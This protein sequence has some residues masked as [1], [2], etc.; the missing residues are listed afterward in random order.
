MSTIL[1]RL[2]AEHQRTP[3][4]SDMCALCRDA[5]ADV[6]DRD[7][8]LSIISSAYLIC[9]HHDAPAHILDVLSDPEA[10]TAAQIDAMLPYQP[11]ARG[12]LSNG[13]IRE[14][15]HK[16][17]RYMGQPDYYSDTEF[18][19]LQDVIGFARAIIAAAAG[20]A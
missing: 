4:H 18:A 16:H 5:A 2:L 17:S 13:A 12:E 9:G 1:A 11:G 15:L 20:A 8:L 7:K 14:I 3:H 19:C 10:A 6:A